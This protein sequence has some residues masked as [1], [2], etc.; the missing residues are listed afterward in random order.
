[1]ATATPKRNRGRFYP[2]GFGATATSS[3]WLPSESFDDVQV[4]ELATRQ[5]KASAVAVP[6][7]FR[8]SFRH[9]VW[10]PP[11]ALGTRD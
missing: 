7:G 10:S 4:A 9:N 8:S 5:A 11:F 3:T 1:M 6:H 2:C